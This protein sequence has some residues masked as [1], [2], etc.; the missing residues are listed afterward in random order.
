[1][2]TVWQVTENDTQIRFYW[3]RTK[4]EAE[5]HAKEYTRDNP[6]YQ[7]EIEPVEFDA[8]RKGITDALN[9]VINL[10]CFNEG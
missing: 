8:N 4:A 2:P 9:W 1:M 6:E 10:T 7:A 3:F 5:V